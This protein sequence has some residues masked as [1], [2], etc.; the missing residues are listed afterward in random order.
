MR[1][2]AE[3]V[4]PWR[5]VRFGVAGGTSLAIDVVLQ[6]LFRAGYGMPI[7]LAPALSH[8]LGLLAHFFAL[9]WWVF[10]QPVTLRRLVQFH[11]TAATAA[12]ITLG[13]TYLL[14]TQ[15]LVP[16]FADVGGPFGTYGPEVAKLV[17]TG[18]A[19]GWTFMSSFFWIWKPEKA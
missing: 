11:V 5:V 4:N 13:I 18:T 1:R 6:R 16:Y 15:P 14:L 9:S 8:E 19:M 3:S 12:V 7:W 2:G 10:R 17:G